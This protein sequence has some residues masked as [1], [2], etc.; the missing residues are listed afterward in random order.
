MKEETFRDSRE[1]WEAGMLPPAAWTNTQSGS[2]G[3]SEVQ[4]GEQRRPDP[5][6]EGPDGQPRSLNLAMQTVG[7][8]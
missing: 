6:V 3:Q 4:A 1:A 8:D 5:R 2:L 7:S